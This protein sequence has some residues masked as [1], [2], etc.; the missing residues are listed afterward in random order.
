M[1]IQLFILLFYFFVNS[2]F[3]TKSYAVYGELYPTDSNFPSQ[4]NV[5]EL[6]KKTPQGTLTTKCSGS[7]ISTSHI[8]T[9][10]HCFDDHNFEVHII[11][12]EHEVPIKSIHIHPQYSRENLFDKD[13]GY[14]YDIRIQNDIAIIETNDIFSEKDIISLAPDESIPLT[15]NSLIVV[16]GFGQVANI[17]GMGSGEGVYRTSHPL[18]IKEMTLSRILVNDGASGSCFGDSGGPLRW[19]SPSGWVQIGVTSQGDCNV[20]SWFERVSLRRLRKE[21]GLQL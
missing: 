7:I 10:A 2:L 6:K 19:L 11:Y 21:F 20:A 15:T 16:S 12:Q 1:K 14:L 17:F 3:S 4:K 13:W 8:L 9:A 5:I 18:K